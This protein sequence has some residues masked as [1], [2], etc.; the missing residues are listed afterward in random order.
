M[1]EQNQASFCLDHLRKKIISTI[2]VFL[3]QLWGKNNQDK[4]FLFSFS[5]SVKIK[6]ELD[7]SFYRSIPLQYFKMFVN[8]IMKIVC[9]VAVVSAALGC[10][11]LRPTTL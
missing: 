2:N 10:I 11:P 5:T 9:T 6:K 8:K 3:R 1:Q 7:F 4:H